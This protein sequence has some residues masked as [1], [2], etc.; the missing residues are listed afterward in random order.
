MR[1]VTCKLNAW[2]YWTIQVII[3]CWRHQME[4]YSALLAFCAGNSPVTGEFPAQRPVTRSFDIFFDLHLNQQLSKPLRRR[5]F[6]TPSRSLWRHCNEHIQ[7]APIHD[8]WSG[9]PWLVCMNIRYHNRYLLTQDMV[10][11]S[12]RYTVWEK[13]FKNVFLSTAVNAQCHCKL[14]FVEYRQICVLCTVFI[15]TNKWH[16]L[17]KPWIHFSLWGFV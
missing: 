12:V 3:T 11:C 1:Q 10:L 5:W 9:K 7:V 2:E 4:A 16:E 15:D 6:E 14:D 13:Q 17:N 8:K